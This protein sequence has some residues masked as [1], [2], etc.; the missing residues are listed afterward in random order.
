MTLD[1]KVTPYKDSGLNKKEQVEK[2]FDTISGNYDG[3]KS[4]DFFWYRPE[5]E[6]KSFKTYHTITNRKAYWTSQPA[7][8]T[9]LLSLQRKLRPLRLQGWICRR[10]CYRLQEKR[11][12]I[13]RIRK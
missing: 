4:P 12:M 6:E 13:L 8:G 7:P 5:V 9:W 2:M 11:S 1:K 10:E 3:S